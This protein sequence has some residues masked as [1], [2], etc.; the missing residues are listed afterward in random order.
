MFSEAPIFT[1]LFERKPPTTRGRHQMPARWQLLASLE[2]T[3]QHHLHYKVANASIFTFMYGL[4]V[5]EVAFL[6]LFLS[7]TWHHVEG[8]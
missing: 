2:W 1:Q 7:A 5:Q 8:M 4:K 6:V 3:E